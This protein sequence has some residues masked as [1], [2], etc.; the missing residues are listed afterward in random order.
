MGADVSPPRWADALLRILIGPQKAETESGDLLE[1]YRDSIYPT[2]GRWR[3]DLWYLRQ[4]LGYGLRARGSKLRN[5]LLA[6]L[7]LCVLT[8]VV[9]AL[10]YPGLLTIPI[11]GVATAGL[12]LYGYAAAFRTRPVTQEDA[13]VLKLGARYGIVLSALWAVG[14]FALNLGIWFGW[15]TVLFAHALP[16]I[17][18]AHAAI[19]LW[20]LR[21]GIRVGFWSGLISGLMTFLILM[22]FGY[23][24]AFVPGLPGAEIPKNLG[25]TAAEY[26]R[27]NVS[28]TLGGGLVFLFALGGAYG[29]ICGAIGGLVG[30]LLALMGRSPEE[31]REICW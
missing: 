1:A 23:I 16:L 24:L 17:A 14:M 21:A 29:V 12:L 5:W 3:A 7:V 15:P 31:S 11:A 4:V 10:R 2:G 26:E 18:G 8:L 25:Y 27:L 13:V 22:A 6:G 30:I 20:S 19:K 28:D 9:T